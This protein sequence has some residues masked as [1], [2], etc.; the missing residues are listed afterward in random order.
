MG[1]V[2]PNNIDIKSVHVV[3]SNDYYKLTYK[4]PYVNV[5]GLILELKNI[6]I[7]PY[8]FYY[9]LIIGDEGSIDLL[10]RIETYLN[11]KVP[12]YK[13]AL[14]YNNSEYYI[15]IKRTDNTTSIISKQCDKSSIHINLLKVIRCA[16]HSCLIIYIL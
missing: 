6:S 12:N 13:Y 11:S 3:G 8:S 7:K 16:F 15:T 4:T 10:K 1:L 5:S 2:I 9:K 14:R